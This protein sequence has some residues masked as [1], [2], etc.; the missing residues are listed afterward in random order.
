[1]AL[2]ASLGILQRPWFEQQLAAHLTG[3]AVDTSAA[4]LALRSVVFAAGCRIELSKSQSFRVA[5]EHA[6][7]YFENALAVYAR[8]LFFK[9]SIMGVQALTLM[10][11][12]RV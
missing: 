2:D 10:V 4:W 12:M 6:W 3:A 7:K 1:M 9:T 11:R 5:A 8:L